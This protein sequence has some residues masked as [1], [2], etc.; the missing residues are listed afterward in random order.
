MKNN[1]IITVFALNPILQ[2]SFIFKYINC[3]VIVLNIQNYYTL[4]F[5]PTTL[6]ILLIFQ[7]GIG[8]YHFSW[9]YP[10][11]DSAQSTASEYHTEI[12]MK[13]T[14]I[15]TEFFYMHYCSVFQVCFEN[16][17][18]AKNQTYSPPSNLGL[19]KIQERNILEF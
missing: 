19:N 14:L 3:I 17:L 12:N 15:W 18:D 9:K 5:V 7:I 2:L 6:I 8:Q 11:S 16:M 13:E 10:V 1:E 4:L